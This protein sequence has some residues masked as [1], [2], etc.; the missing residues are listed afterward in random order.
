MALVPNANIQSLYGINWLAVYY[1]KHMM[2]FLLSI[3][4]PSVVTT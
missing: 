3:S 2:S 1:G 4:S